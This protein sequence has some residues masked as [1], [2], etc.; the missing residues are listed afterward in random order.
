M[1][2]TESPRLVQH[3]AV[4]GFSW[5]KELS[6]I[7]VRKQRRKLQNALK[8]TPASETSLVASYLVSRLSRLFTSY[9]AFSI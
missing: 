2:A 6:Q 1:L 4:N 5:G 7:G 8:R 3:E 9:F